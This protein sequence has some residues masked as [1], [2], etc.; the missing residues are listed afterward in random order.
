[1]DRVRGSGLISLA[2]IF[3]QSGGCLFIWLVFSF[4]VQKSL[5]HIVLFVFAFVSFP[6]DTYTKKYF[7][8]LT[9]YVFF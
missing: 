2:I 7:K 6:E 8:E 3:A 4:T 5:F 9:A 1:M